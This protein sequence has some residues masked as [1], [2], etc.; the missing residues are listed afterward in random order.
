MIK[1]DLIGCEGSSACV[2]YPNQPTSSSVIV[3]NFTQDPFT[4]HGELIQEIF[5]HLM[6][7]RNVTQ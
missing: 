4:S 3:G 5:I 1:I 2:R 7:M 6:I